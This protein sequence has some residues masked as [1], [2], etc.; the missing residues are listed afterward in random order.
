M[1]STVEMAMGIGF[2]IA[3]FPVWEWEWEG[4]GKTVYGNGNDPSS[5]GTKIPTDFL[6]L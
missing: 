1:P 4:M 2:P 5:H 6:L 3:M